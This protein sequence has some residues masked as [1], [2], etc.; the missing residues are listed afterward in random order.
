LELTEIKHLYDV[1]YGV[2]GR[3]RFAAT[4][5]V[6]RGGHIKWVPKPTDSL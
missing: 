6:P 2:K 4:G 3:F 5:T 1:D